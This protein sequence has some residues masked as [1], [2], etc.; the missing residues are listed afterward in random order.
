MSSLA[1][2]AQVVRSK[3]AGPTQLTIDVFFRD[4]QGFALA[5][6]SPALSAQAVAQR[7]GVAAQDMQRHVMPQILAMKFSMPRALCAGT[8]GDGDVY[9]A[10]Q[11]MPLL[12]IEL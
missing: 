5:L 10:Q 12:E 2:L 9:G 4:A 7:Y 3:N 6:Q 1:S 8:P 11:H